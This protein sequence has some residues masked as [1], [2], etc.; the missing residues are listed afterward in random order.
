MHDS[1]HSL[2]TIVGKRQ[3]FLESLEKN[4]KD[5]CE[6]ETD[7]DISRSTVDR[8]IREL[9][10]AGLVTSTNSDYQLTL[11]GRTALT[12]AQQYHRRLQEID[13]GR[14]LLSTLPSGIDI[15]DVF[16]DG[17]S[18]AQAS[19]EIPDR[20]IRYLFDS[21]ESADVFRGVSPVA[22]AGYLDEF[23]AVTTA[24]GTIVKHVVDEDVVE[25]LLAA[26]ELRSGFIKQ[27]QHDRVSLLS[28]DIS[29]NYGVWIVDDI[30]A[31][32]VFYTDTG[33][34]GIIINDSDAAIQ[35]AHNQWES[36]MADATS[37]HQ[38]TPQVANSEISG[39]SRMENTVSSTEDID[40]DS[41]L[42]TNSNTET[43]DEIGAQTEQT[44][45][46]DSASPH[47]DQTTQADTET[48][49]FQDNSGS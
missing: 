47:E 13:S 27:A 45:E 18:Y 28:G 37:I 8:G 3:S 7:L 22:L 41:N 31:G 24:N 35:W 46:S 19:P 30:E 16:L 48:S 15:A 6:L 43:T 33:V 12:A 2:D 42:E 17:A 1:D 9:S 14:D 25:T 32:I 23:Y 29:F 34:R 40:V 10:N 44:A 4:S 26:P 5:K 36:V 39:D 21:I 38:S 20:I 49:E 11:A